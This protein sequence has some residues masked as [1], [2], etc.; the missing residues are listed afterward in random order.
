[1]NTL[2]S[3]R[4]RHSEL[5][6]M[7]SDLKIMLNPEQLKVK[8]H[9]KMTHELLCAL[10]RKLQHHLL[11]EDKGVYPPLLTQEDA[12]LK[13][14]AW[15]LISGQKPLRTQFD[16]YHRTWLKNCD[17]KFTEAFLDETLEV[18]SMIEDR[19][20]REKTVLLPKLEASGLFA[21]NPA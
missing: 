17:F 8:P 18:F 2:T 20:E 4:E 5:L 6:G 16:E 12:K 9:A 10:G 14:L 11:E 21:A 19:I 15:G 3:L 1:M 13:S 7:I